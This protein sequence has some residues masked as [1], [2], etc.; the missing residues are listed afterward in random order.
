MPKETHVKCTETSAVIFR[1][2]DEERR[3]GVVRENGREK[4]K[5]KTKDNIHV[6]CK[7]R[8]MDETKRGGNVEKSEGSR[9]V[10]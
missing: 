6:N 9:S 3:T 8:I 5:R 1:T 10:E 4:G 7:Y 2:C